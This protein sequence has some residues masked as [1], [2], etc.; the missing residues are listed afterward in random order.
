MDDSLAKVLSFVVFIALGYMLRRFGILKP[1]AFSAIS[2]L[3]MD[4]TLPCVII[5][6]LNGLRIAGDMLLAAIFGFAVNLALL[7]WAKL[8]S[9]RDK[10]PMMRDFKLLN[11]SGYSVGPFAIP[12]MQAFYP[13][14]GLLAVCMFDVG[15]VFMAGGGTYALIAGTREKTTL[16]GTLKV[17]FSKLMRSGPLVC[18]VFV[19]LMSVFSLKLPDGVITCAKVAA[20]ANAFLC[21]IMV[22]EAIEF[23]MSA[24]KFFLLLRILALRWVICIAL[25]LAAYNFLPFDGEMRIALS[26]VCLSPI[27][28]MNLIF[29][30][31]LGCDI[32][33]GANLNSMNVAC[34]VA[35]MSVALVML[36]VA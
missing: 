9:F 21:M 7:A 13:T 5:A 16:M 17:I 30:A 1:E 4:V 6:N 20:G 19:I 14:T 3:V 22:G 27:P 10:D 26:L 35:A 31:K 2:G 28:A 24:S 25:A 15:N 18:F 23:N 11:M 8:W 12:Y 32:S 36:G 29:T 34:S 33:L